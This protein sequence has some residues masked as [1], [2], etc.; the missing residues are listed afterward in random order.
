[1]VG[2]TPSS[3]V[4]LDRLPLEIL[5]TISEFVLGDLGFTGLVFRLG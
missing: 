5:T 2:H 4:S 3:A 1:M